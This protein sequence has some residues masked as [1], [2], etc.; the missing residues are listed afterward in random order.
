MGS[1]GEQEGW[2]AQALAFT[3]EQPNSASY[4]FPL[5]KAGL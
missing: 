3:P 1:E 5:V 4:W 2:G